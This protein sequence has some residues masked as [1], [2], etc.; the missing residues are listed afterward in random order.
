MQH[1]PRVLFI[2]RFLW[3]DEGISVGL[4][5]LAKGLMKQGWEVALASAMEEKTQADGEITRGPEWFESYGIKHFFVPFPNFRTFKGKNPSGAVQALLKLN[6]AVEQFKPDVINVHSLSMCPYAHAMRL[7]YKIPFVS[8]A[9]IE[10]VSSRRSVQIGA[11]VNQYFGTFLGDRFIAISTEVKD[12]Y[13]HTLKVPKENIRLICHGVDNDHFRPPSGQERLEAREAF[14]LA[15]KSQVVCLIGR[16]DPVKGHDVLYRALAILKSGG[17]KV[18][19]LCAGTGG[20]WKDE[21]QTLATEL[22]VDDCVRFLGFTDTRQVL[23]AS[24][25][26]ILPS[27]REGFGW[28]IP[29]AMLCGVVPLRTPSAGAIDQIEDG[30]NG[31]IFPFDDAAALALRLKQLFENEALRG[32]MSGAALESARQKFTADRMIKDTIAVYEEV[33]NKGSV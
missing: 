16:L 32:Q 15:P 14:E 18:T 12:V 19:A 9:R 5:R 26:L 21:I 24:D 1:K 33:I 23:W 7:F 10:P 17:I 2:V 6:A 27:R 4:V 11:F 31:F 20:K 22:G 29:E 30:L 28:V 3:G 25:V 13:E 8:T